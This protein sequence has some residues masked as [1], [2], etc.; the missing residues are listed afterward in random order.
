MSCG[1]ISKGMLPDHILTK[2]QFKLKFIYRSL[3]LTC[4]NFIVTIIFYCRCCYVPTLQSGWLRHREVTLRS[5]VT[6]LVNDWA[7]TEAWWASGLQSPHLQP[8]WSVTKEQGGPWRQGRRLE[9]SGDPELDHQA[10]PWPGPHPPLLAFLSI[11]HPP[12]FL[13]RNPCHSYAFHWFPRWVS[14]SKGLFMR[15]LRIL[16]TLRQQ[17][18]ED[19]GDRK[20]DAWWKW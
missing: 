17:G 2:T 8:L 7:Q 20:P 9:H 12:R 16:T 11:S 5:R 13:P 15:A 4:I 19:W 10:L 1:N 3:V 14:V 18:R 6:Q